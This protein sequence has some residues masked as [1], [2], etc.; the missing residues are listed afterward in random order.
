[1]SPRAPAGNRTRTCS[2]GG[3]HTVLCTTG[4]SNCF[5]GRKV[6]DARAAPGRVAPHGDVDSSAPM[7]FRRAAFSSAK[8]RETPFVPHGAIL[9]L[10]LV[11]EAHIR[12]LDRRAQR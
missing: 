11:S 1:M 5:Q 9:P 4:A 3:R 2:L 10:E 12:R 8:G 6:T 7:M